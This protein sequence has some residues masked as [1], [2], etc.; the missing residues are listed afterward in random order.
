MYNNI[1]SWPSQIW[2]DFYRIVSGPLPDE[3]EIC[4]EHMGA[5]LICLFIILIMATFVN[6][7]IAIHGTAVCKGKEMVLKSIAEASPEERIRIIRMW[8]D[9]HGLKLKEAAQVGKEDKLKGSR[10]F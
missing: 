7:T 4:S 10:Q 6:G 5:I 2:D 8:C 1:L 3:P 9:L